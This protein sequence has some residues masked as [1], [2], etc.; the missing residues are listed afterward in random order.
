MLNRLGE[1]STHIE[2]FAKERKLNLH[3]NHIRESG[4]AELFGSNGIK[5]IGARS[6]QKKDRGRSKPTNVAR[7]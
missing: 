7:I 2:L 4:G 3:N 6:R 5:N 1:K